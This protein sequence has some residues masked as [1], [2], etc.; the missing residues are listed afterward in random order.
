MDKSS[1]WVTFLNSN[2]NPMFIGVY[3]PYLTHNWVK[4]TQNFF[5]VY[6]ESTIANY[7]KKHCVLR[8]L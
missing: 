6:N 2:F 8:L 1:H 5:K 4:T 3:T 7:S